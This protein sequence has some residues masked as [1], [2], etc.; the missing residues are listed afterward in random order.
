MK[1]IA[2]IGAGIS[3]LSAAQMLKNKY[4]VHVFEKEKTAG[5]LIRCQTIQNNLFHLSGGHVFNTKNEI[6]FNWI[7]KFLSFEQD[8]Y[9]IKRNASIYL[10]KDYISY[11]I[12]NN[13]WQ[14]PKKS[15]S[16]VIEELLKI[17]K[18]QFRTFTELCNHFENFEN[19]LKYNFGDTLF[20][21]YFKTYNQKIWRT[22][23]SK[24]PLYWLKNKLPMPD[25]HKILE[26]NINRESENKMVHSHFYYP[27]NGGSQFII[28][29][30]SKDLTI[31]YN[32]EIKVR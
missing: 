22:D 3:G 23:L 15:I 9:K 5:G 11:P 24:I 21:I 26:S 7:K 25:I 2:I 14:L 20:N 8:F 18:K 27:R 29:K 13:L 19:F 1:K 17:E 12:E 32:L 30:L 16:K 31:H 6:V 10:N 28:N 4:K